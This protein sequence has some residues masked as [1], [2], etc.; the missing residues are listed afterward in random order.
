MD[1]ISNQRNNTIDNNK[2]EQIWRFSQEATNLDNDFSA[3]SSQLLS[4]SSLLSLLSLSS[5]ETALPLGKPLIIEPTSIGYL[6][7]INDD[8]LWQKRITVP[9]FQEPLPEKQKIEEPPAISVPDGSAYKKEAIRMI[10]IRRRK[11]KKH[12]LKKLRRKMKFEWAKVRQ[13]REMRKE[14]AFQAKLLTQIKEAE[15]FD[16]EK[17]VS[18]KL[19]KANEVPLP[20]HWKGR[21]LPAFI[22]KQKL[23]IE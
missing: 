17:F 12:K 7:E 15:Q 23:G 10:V 13:R 5:I 21:R 6:N 11:M 16:A 22:I 18:E 9:G 20:R 14:K 2:F 8:K 4:S 3:R 1:S 19:R